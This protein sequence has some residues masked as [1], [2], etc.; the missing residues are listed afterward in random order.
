M[1]YASVQQFKDRIDEQ[2]VLQLTTRDGATVDDAAVQQALDDAAAVIDGYL[3][4]VTAAD[5]PSP[6][7]LLPY[8]VDIAVYRLAR[9]R[10]GR[11]FESIQAAYEAAVKFLTRLAEGRF[12]GAGQSTS[13]TG[14]AVL[15]SGPPRIFS[16]DTMGD[17]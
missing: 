6:A 3:E 14:G 11:E 4:R 10:P 12:A 15:Y 8:A 5:R 16:T 17:F 2:I 9:S 13:P 7:V 1:T